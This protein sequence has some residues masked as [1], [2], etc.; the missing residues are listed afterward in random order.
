MARRKQKKSKAAFIII[1]LIILACIVGVWYFSGDSTTHPKESTPAQTVTPTVVPTQTP[2]P[3]Q[4]ATPVS[5]PVA[6]SGKEL[7][8]HFINIGQGDAILLTYDGKNAMVDAGKSTKEA[9]KSEVAIDT[10]LN[11]IDGLE[12]LLATHQ[13]SDHIGLARH[14]MDSEKTDMFYDNGNTA[15]T[16]TYTKLMTYISDNNI[17]Y[18]ILSTGDTINDWDNV[19][20]SVVS[21]A[22]TGGKDLNDDSI[23]LLVEYGNTKIALTGDISKDVESEIGK[24]LGDIDILKVAHHGSKSSSSSSFLNSVKPEVSV[25]SVGEN[26]YGHPTNEAI[27][28]LDDYG[29]VYRTDEFGCVEVVVTDSGYTV[30]HCEWT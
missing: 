16:Y 2:A 17:N 25:I 22:P 28:R 18:K 7:K 11:K 27:D 24:R 14:V 19:K 23:V 10:H 12:W 15:D 29:D 6:S 4:I 1:L 20:I 13:D 8:I 21:S 3:T 5:T 9:A 30:Q 26:S